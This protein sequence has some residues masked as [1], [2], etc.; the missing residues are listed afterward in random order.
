MI[1]ALCRDR[2]P[3]GGLFVRSGGMNLC[4]DRAESAGIDALRRQEGKK[5][6][7][8]YCGERMLAGM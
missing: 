6:A 8:N 2:N 4:K 3:P 5:F 1:R 7:A